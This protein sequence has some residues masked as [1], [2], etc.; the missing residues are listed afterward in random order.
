MKQAIGAV[1]LNL[2]HSSL[3]T[4][5]QSRNRSILAS[6][7]VNYGYDLHLQLGL[8][9]CCDHRMFYKAEPIMN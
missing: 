2:L 8:F 9:T 7:Y 3:V 4:Y 6:L 1:L 5:S